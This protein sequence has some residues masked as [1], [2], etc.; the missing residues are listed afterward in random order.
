[1]LC[2]SSCFES[3][4]ESFSK[5]PAFYKLLNEGFCVFSKWCHFTLWW[6]VY[7]FW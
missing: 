4:D 6:L 3:K 5:Y 7:I 1:M 2:K